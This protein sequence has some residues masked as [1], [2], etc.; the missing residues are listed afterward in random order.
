MEGKKNKSRENLLI[1]ERTAYA[2]RNVCRKGTIKELVGF[3]KGIYIQGFADGSDAEVLDDDD[4]AI[5]IKRGTTYECICPY[6]EGEMSLD[7][8][9]LL[10]P[11]EE[12]DRERQHDIPVRG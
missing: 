6:C 9:S 11:E 3:L 7:L 4:R 8:Y 2:L 1:D 10:T 5:R 12:I